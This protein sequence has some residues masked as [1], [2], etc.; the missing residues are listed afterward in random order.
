MV[1]TDK[2]LKK[3]SINEFQCSVSAGKHVIQVTNVYRRQYIYAKSIQTLKRPM[4][5]NFPL[6]HGIEISLY[7][8]YHSTSWSTWSCKSDHRVCRLSGLWRVVICCR[9]GNQYPCWLKTWEE[10][11]EHV[12]LPGEEIECAVVYKF[13]CSLVWVDLKPKFGT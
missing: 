2:E 7:I 12:R 11:V 6:S 1:L 9:Q 13:L 5:S 3:F 4:F 8:K 10:T